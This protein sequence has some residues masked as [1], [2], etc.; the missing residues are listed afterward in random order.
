MGRY[1]NWSAASTTL[2]ERACARHGGWERYARR[3][4]VSAQIVGLGGPLP[5]MKGLGKTFPSPHR[6]VVSPH[7]Q[8]TRFVDWPAPQGE[9]R[10]ERGSVSIGA[11][12]AE[13]EARDELHRGRMPRARWEP[14]D[15]LYFF[16]YALANYF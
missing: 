1:S 6:V 9:G 10:F 5:A 12:G 11:R 15:G 8:R 4:E 13:A 3:A 2:V 16:G 14:L 7:E